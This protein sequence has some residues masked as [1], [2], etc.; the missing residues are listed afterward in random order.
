M[1][2]IV[3][4]ETEE[5]S[6]T[7]FVTAGSTS[8]HSAQPFEM[9]IGI[10]SATTINRLTVIWPTGVQESYENIEVGSETPRFLIREGESTPTRLP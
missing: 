2:S 7:K 1:G 9:H 3:V 6:Q 4:I 10:G 5:N 8:V